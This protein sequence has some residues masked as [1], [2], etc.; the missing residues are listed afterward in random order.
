MSAPKIGDEDVGYGPAMFLTSVEVKQFNQHLQSVS[1]EDL[2][3]NF[4][5]SNMLEADIYVF[6]NT[7]AE[8]IEEEKEYIRHYYEILRNTISEAAQANQALIMYIA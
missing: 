3:K 6:R 2:L 1:A 8:R 7:P 4:T 5:E